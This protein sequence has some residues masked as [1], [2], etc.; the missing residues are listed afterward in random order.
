MERKPWWNHSV[1]SYKEMRWVGVSAL[2]S[3]NYLYALDKSLH[4]G[5]GRRGVWFSLI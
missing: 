2:L 3:T 4:F 5:R 1:G